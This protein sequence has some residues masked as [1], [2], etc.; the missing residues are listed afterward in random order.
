MSFREQI[1]EEIEKRRKLNPNS[2]KTYVSILFNLHK[3]LATDDDEKENLKWFNDEKVIL[4]HLKERSPKVRKTILSALFIL[5]GNDEYRKIMIN[6]CKIVNDDYK[7]QKKNPKQEEGWIDINDIMKIY[8]EHLNRFKDIFQK[9]TMGSYSEIMD[10][11][12]LGLLGGVSGLPPRRSLDYAQMKIKNY[13]TKKDNYYKAGKFYFNIYKTVD[14]YGTQVVDVK[15]LAPELNANIMKWIKSDPTDYL[16]FSTNKNP[17]TSP[18]I[19]R[20]LNRIFGK[21]TSTDLLRHIYLTDKYKN[22]PALEEMEKRA[23]EMGHSLNT[24]MEY[25]KR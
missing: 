16:L 23:S 7:Q 10:Y 14:T 15:S 5:T 3:S 8:E 18:Q 24:S 25:I 19:T 1:K 22:V 6:D 4:E 12:L 20:M 9:K 2:V 21:R 17:L 11:L 13:D